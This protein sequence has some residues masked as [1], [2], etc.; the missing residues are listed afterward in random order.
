MCWVLGVASARGDEVA[1]YLERHGLDGL[2][3][4][5]LEERLAS[6]PGDER[7]SLVL[8]L[9]GIY[10]RLLAST[11]DPVLLRNLQERS[12][13]LLSAVS[14]EVGQELQL[15]LLRGA[16]RGAETIA[17]AVEHVCTPCLLTSLTTAIGFGSL[18]TSDIRPVADF[19]VAA[20][21]A[22]LLTFG[23]TMLVV[24]A[25]AALMAPPSPKAMRAVRADALGNAA[26]YLARNQHG[27]DHPADIVNGAIAHDMNSAGVLLNL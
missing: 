5:H 10:A 4:V 23:V 17:A 24:P 15:A 3:A 12:R 14:P 22:A 18:L 11:D 2:L 6:V 26:M 27:V 9:V 21:L 16:Y 1:A 20:A 25:A 7:E 13:R 8:Q 19:G